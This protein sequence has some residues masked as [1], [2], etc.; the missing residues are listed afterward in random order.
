MSNIDTI[1]SNKISG[2]KLSESQEKILKKW[3]SAEGNSLIFKELEKV[4]QLSGNLNFKMKVPNVEAEW[5]SFK[6]IQKRQQAKK[7]YF[8]ISALA[9]SV[10]LLIGLF[11]FLPEKSI[12]Y[13]YSQDNKH[14]IL[15]DSSDV[16]LNKHS[17]IEFSKAFGKKNRNIQLKG[18]AFFKVR[19]GNVP[20]IVNT[21]NK[22]SA[23]VLGTSFNV[24]KDANNKV[25]L[26]VLSGLVEFGNFSTQQVLKV[27]KGNE[28][29]YYE[30]TDKLTS[31]TL[32]NENTVSWA[33]GNFYFNESKLSEVLTLLE[34]YL[35]IKIDI[36]NSL[37][38]KKF[39]GKFNQPT[40]QEIQQVLG[41]AFDLNNTY[42]NKKLSFSEKK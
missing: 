38:D 26:Q 13:K 11:F 7:L 22:V 35:L 16:W 42:K 1:I 20:F 41:K 15:P 2:T 33:T 21:S 37:K 27:K 12:V 14:F 5:K 25:Y 23:K 3:L 29:I 24:K 36:P 4:W 32:K 8:T 18:E 39:S 6:N 17:S 28:A 34:A 30:N 9:A 19:K 31:S 10:I 40:I